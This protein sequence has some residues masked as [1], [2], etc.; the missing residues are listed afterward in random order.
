MKN[1]IK[2]L[3]TI[4]IFLLIQLLVLAFLYFHD[5]PKLIFYDF[6]ITSV[7]SL[8]FI[9]FIQF[10]KIKFLKKLIPIVIIACYS[11]FIYFNIERIYIGN[12]WRF[13]IENKK[14]LSSWIV[15][16]DIKQP[17]KI[18]QIEFVD[19]NDS[20]YFLCIRK[21]GIYCEGIAY[22]IKKGGETASMSIFFIKSDWIHIFGNWYYWNG[23][24]DY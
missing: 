14:E 11:L 6:I 22:S 3:Y 4:Q 1:S 10:L 23:Y 21:K 9:I 20:T 19:I 8:F 2:L 12:Y 18:D 16:S 24:D 17:P 5:Y 7:F 13:I 15:R